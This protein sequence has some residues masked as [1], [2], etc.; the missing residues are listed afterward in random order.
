MNRKSTIIT[1]HAGAEG[2]VANSLDSIQSLSQTPADY[3]ELDVRH[4]LDGKAVLS[5]D[6]YFQGKKISAT[7]FNQLK[8]D[9]ICSYKEA[10]ELLLKAGKKINTD[11]KSLEVI[12]DVARVI[13]EYQANEVILLSGCHPHHASYISEHYP[14]MNKI[15]NV[16]ELIKEANE[17]WHKA[18]MDILKICT[19]NEINGINIPHYQL[20]EN[21]MAF[22]EQH[23][24]LCYV[25][26]VDESPILEE[27]LK[28][29]VES[30]TT[31]NVHNLYKRLISE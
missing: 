26:T 6:D 2:T 7:T 12:D 27:V 4:T 5:H 25:W 29:K 21:I 20:D 15:L 22:F 3:I 11:I 28:Y 9:G 17:Q 18:C 13:E 24:L 16:D 31:N 19:D 23:D 14:W 30:I 8:E 1:A 10:V